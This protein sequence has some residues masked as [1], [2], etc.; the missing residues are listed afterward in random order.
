MAGMPSTPATPPARPA[1]VHASMSLLRD[2]AEHSLD[3]GYAAAAAHR[4][5]P[6][7]PNRPPGG[8]V[9]ALLVVLLL[10]GLLFGVAAAQSS[11]QAPVLSRQE[12]GLRADIVR[13]TRTVRGLAA[14]GNALRRQIA[15][16]TVTRAQLAASTA[17]AAA[18]EA[19]LAVAT[20]T[21]AVSGPGL[22]VRLTDAADRPI[23]DTDLQAVVNA[24]WAAGAEGQA[25]NGMR[26]TARSA[27]RT[28]GSAILVNL[29]PVSPP[30]VVEAIGSPN[31]LAARFAETGATARLRAAAAV[32][33]IGFA[34][35]P[36]DSVTLPPASF[37]GGAP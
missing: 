18:T 28:A 6:A 20:G 27:I 11:R 23:T 7:T 35:I 8:R 2:L 37:P 1:A 10:G 33:G 12:L 19:A 25:V 16:G 34:A 21:T 29:R 31:T 17:R 3:A 5:G 4:G 22:V 36:V 24:L 32:F 9:V 13:A 15:A 26:L 30:Y 14:A